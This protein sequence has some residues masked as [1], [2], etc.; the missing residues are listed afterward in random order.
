ML[1]VVRVEHGKDSG[2]ILSNVI[3]F[4]MVTESDT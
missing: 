4:E 3:E 1:V 2:Y